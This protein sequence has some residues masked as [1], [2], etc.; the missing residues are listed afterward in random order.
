M[1]GKEEKNSDELIVQVK[2]HAECWD[3]AKKY[4]KEKAFWQAEND[5]ETAWKYYEAGQYQEAEELFNRIVSEFSNLPA[6]FYYKENLARFYMDLEQWDKAISLFE[7]VV[8]NQPANSDIN[9]L[10]GEGY[11]RT[12][13]FAKAIKRLNQYTEA[14]GQES[15]DIYAEKLLSICHFLRFEKKS[16]RLLVQNPSISVDELYG[17]VRS[18]LKSAISNEYNVI[19]HD[20][21]L[22][23][24]QIEHFDQ[25][26][27][28]LDQLAT[29]ELQKHGIP[30]S[31]NRIQYGI[32]GDAVEDLPA[33]IMYTEFDWDQPVGSVYTAAHYKDPHTD[34]N[35]KII[36]SVLYNSKKHTVI[37]YDNIGIVNELQKTVIGAIKFTYH[38]DRKDSIRVTLL[39]D[40][41]HI[42]VELSGVAELMCFSGWHKTASSLL[43]QC[44]KI[45]SLSKDQQQRL[46]SLDS[47]NSNVQKR[48]A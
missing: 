25:M 35:I 37:Q 1:T 32:L 23:N 13:Q 26:C 47:L 31:L 30:L 46:Q 34:K 41:D 44:A 36:Y 21:S 7:E 8:D 45:P 29:G 28:T 18:D 43:Q 27:R 15:I 42:F 14:L 11:A 24:K 40:Q 17:E 5:V 10:L 22:T 48:G 2:D 9:R 6:C 39:R 12:N 4:G 20:D 19:S 33:E 38:Q 3:E 16:K